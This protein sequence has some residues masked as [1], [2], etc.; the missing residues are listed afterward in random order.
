MSVSRSLHIIRKNMFNSFFASGQ[1]LLWIRSPFGECINWWI[2]IGFG[3]SVD[4]RDIAKVT[5]ITYKPWSIGVFPRIPPHR[6]PIIDP[7]TMSM[8]LKRISSWKKSSTAAKSS[9]QLPQMFAGSVLPVF[10]ET[11][12][13]LWTFHPLFSQ[14]HT[15]APPEV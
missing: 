1:V 2:T 14:L 11:D 4:I 7:S 10:W 15:N 12:G 13:I 5:I 6:L 9:T 8:S 3:E